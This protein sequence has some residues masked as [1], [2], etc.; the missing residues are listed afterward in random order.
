[1]QQ[2]MNKLSKIYIAGHTGLVGS[3]IV[4]ALKKDWYTNLVFRTI[5]ELDLMNQLAVEKFFSEE[6]P[7]YVI[8]AA[9]KVGGIVANRDYPADFIYQNLQIQNNVIHN[10]WKF[11]VK[12]LLFLGSSCIYPKHSPQPMKEEYLLTDILEPS[13]EPYAIA[14][15]AWIKMCQSYNRQY[16]SN[17][18]ACMPT[19]LYGPGDNFDLETSHVLPAMIRKFHEAKING[20]KVTLRG[21]GSPMREFLYVDDMAKA[22]LYLMENVDCIVENDVCNLVCGDVKIENTNFVNIWTG[23]DVTIRQLAETV[24]DV[25]WFSWEI[26][27]DTDKPNGT[28]RKLQDVSKLSE[29]GWEYDVEL[30]DGVEMGYEWFLEKKCDLMTLIH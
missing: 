20:T 13:N 26:I 9:A 15:I 2:I 11:E 5:E 18:I 30:R 28:P 10:S 1:M 4:R 17:F 19:N 14:K 12:K 7:E 8:L 23:K 3:A 21:D 6:K 29:M 27:W 22:C 24:A 16:W 25:V